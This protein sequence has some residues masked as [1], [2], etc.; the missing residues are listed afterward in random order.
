M[1]KTV[2]IALNIKS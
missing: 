1:D 2:Q